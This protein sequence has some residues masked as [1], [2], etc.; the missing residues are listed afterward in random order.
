MMMMMMNGFC[1]MVDRRKV[2][3]LISN[4]DHCQRSSPSRIS[5]TPWAGFEPALSL[6]SGLV[7]WSCASVITTTPRRQ[8]FGG[9]NL[10]DCIDEDESPHELKH[11]S[12]IHEQKEKGEWR[13]PFSN[14]SC[15]YL[16][17]IWIRICW[18]LYNYFR[19]IFSSSKCG[20]RK[21]HSFPK[22]FLIKVKNPKKP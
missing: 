20:F 2:F 5:D 21:G 10:N 17:N 8:K 15:K 1:G 22:C 12:S 19:N 4:R 18:N 6:S 3:S 11:A 13:L 14:H 7:E 16:W 9:E